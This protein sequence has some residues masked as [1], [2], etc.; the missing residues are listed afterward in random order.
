MAIQ[1]TNRKGKIYFLHRGTR[2]DGR[3]HYYFST[4]KDDVKL[5]EELPEG[6]EIFEKPFSGQVF[7][8]KKLIS[9]I[10]QEE[11]TLANDLLASCCELPDFAVILERT[12]N[13]IIVHESTCA[14]DLL[15]HHAKLDDDAPDL[16]GNVIHAF[17]FPAAEEESGPDQTSLKKMMLN[18]SGFRSEPDNI[19]VSQKMV[20]L[21][22]FW[23][24]LRFELDKESE[25]SERSFS[26]YRFN[27]SSERWNY[28]SNGNLGK[29]LKQYLP[30]LGKDSFFE[31]G[32]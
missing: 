11:W 13:E 21:R 17:G 18:Y 22:D 6:R 15:A 3:D 27:F 30:H 12:R 8:R 9:S 2:K 4:S 20:S 7:L 31:I 1:H 28:L 16:S 26:A 5:V 32:L 19:L 10:L 25:T 24:A 23:P 14:G 29:G